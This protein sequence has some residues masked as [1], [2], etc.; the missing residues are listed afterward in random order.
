MQKMRRCLIGH[1]NEACELAS[2]LNA[3]LY[4]PGFV[5]IICLSSNL[6]TKFKGQNFPN[7]LILVYFNSIHLYTSRWTQLRLQRFYDI[8]HLNS[9]KIRSKYFV[10]YKTIY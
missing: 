3:K 8:F 6:F 2:R 9:T 10:F 4:N 1:V 7:F 5:N